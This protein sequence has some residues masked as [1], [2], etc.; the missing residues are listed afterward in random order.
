MKKILVLALVLTLCFCG[1]AFTAVNSTIKIGVI[2]PL[3]GP[4]A[5]YGIAVK[6]AVELFTNAVNEAGG[7][8]G[9]KIEL[10]AYDDKHDPTEALN[11]YN[12]LV[13]ADEVAAIIGP[14]TSSPT[15]GV[16]QASAADNF[17][18]ITPTATHPDVT[19]YGNNYFRACFED[20]FQGGAMVR[21]A[22]EVLKARTAAVIYNV[23]DA[24]STGLYNSF[25]QNA[26]KVGLE[27]VAAES[28]STDEVDFSVQLSNIAGKNPD[29][30]FI[31]DY[32]NTL[33]L[34]CSQ[35]K[36][37]GIKS[38][39]LGVDGADGILEIEGVDNSIV[40]GI[41]FVNHYFKD[42][43]SDIVQNFCKGYEAAY[44]ITPNALGALGYD[45]AAILYNA[46]ERAIDAGVE[47]GANE[48]SYKALIDNMAS[49]S[50]ECVT[51]HIT[52]ENNNPV[53]DVTVI[54][55]MDGKY[56]F[57]SKYR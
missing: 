20:P 42:D 25:K 10:I 46:I 29:V 43:P 30:L 38:I 31:P 36:R 28:Y 4:V 39:P 41:Y 6:N 19:T 53:K 18:G 17:P 34:I 21:F 8:R 23:S 44:G 9:H 48:K 3:T 55:I 7:I 56:T 22:S 40:N 1:T 13:A 27:V 35:A 33:Y 32:Y 52:F 16:A 57:E 11:S 50:L 5:V 49:T 12:R 37:A 51:G 2:A 15:F 45:G 54:K 47:I 14:V 24:Y 26:E